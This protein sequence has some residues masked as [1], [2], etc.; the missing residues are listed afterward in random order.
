MEGWVGLERLGGGEDERE[1]ERKREGTKGEG[2]GER[3]KGRGRIYRGGIDLMNIG[4][5]LNT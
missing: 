2:E 1:E 5:L 3:E 4:K